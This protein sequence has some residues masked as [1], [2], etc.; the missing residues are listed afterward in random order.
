MC[1]H[2]TRRRPFSVLACL[3]L[4]AALLAACGGP[5]A[6]SEATPVAV[7]TNTPRPTD[8][9]EPSPTPTDTP[10]LTPTATETSIPTDTP[11]A[12]A[13]ATKR[14]TATPRPT[15]TATPASSGSS[16]DRYIPRT[17]AEIVEE[18]AAFIEPSEALTMYAEMSPE[19]SFPSR[20]V[21]TYTGQFRETLP[22]RQGFIAIWGSSLGIASLEE[23]PEI[24]PQEV[25]VVEDGVE[26]WIPV[27]GVLVPYMEDE[28]EAGDEVILFVIWAGAIMES[29]E[30]D[31][32]FLINEF[33][34][35]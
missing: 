22:R 9:A 10:T 19:Y 23:M 20:V 26:Y 7:V 30:I 16:W 3:W 34:D 13:T 29:G 6:E 32:V 28:L 14:P 5:S 1:Y 12:T 4:L 11:A 8:T 18:S 25:L 27:Q 2:S 24:F 31:R 35:N 15:H 33:T 17:L 21:V